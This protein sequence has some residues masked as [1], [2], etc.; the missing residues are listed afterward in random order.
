MT[1]KLFGALVDALADRDLLERARQRLARK[2]E[3][4]EA[5][6]SVPSLGASSA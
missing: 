1:P 4:I 6:P 2:A 5:D 3:A